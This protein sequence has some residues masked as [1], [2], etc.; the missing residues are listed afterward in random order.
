MVIARTSECTCYQRNRWKW[1][2]ISNISRVFVLTL[3]KNECLRGNGGCDHTCINYFGAHEC[4]CNKGYELM[5]DKQRC[6]GKL[7][8]GWNAPNLY[9]SRPL[10]FPS[11]PSIQ[12][13]ICVWWILQPN[14]THFVAY[15]Q[16][17][18]PLYSTNLGYN[19]SF[20]HTTLY[21]TLRH[22]SS[23]NYHTKID[24]DWAV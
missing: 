1:V 22:K 21:N 2:R 8:Y 24:I 7:L 11:I 12:I 10:L 19:P 23:R 16:L 6:R 14:C 20:S 3:V 18:M 4:E 13:D 17:R 15:N 5:S 9:V